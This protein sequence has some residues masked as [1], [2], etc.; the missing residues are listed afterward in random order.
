[1]T[2]SGKR[3]VHLGVAALSL[4]AILASVL[5]AHNVGAAQITDRSLTL[6]P[7]SGGDAGSKPGG[8]VNHFFQFTV[9]TTGTA[10][11]SIKFQYCTTASGTCTMPSNMSSTT[12]TLGSEGSND[13]GFTLN[14]TTNGAPFLYKASATTPTA[15]SLSYTLDGVKNPDGA[16]CS[17]V[18]C[19]FF[20]RIT[21]YQGTDGTTTPIDSGTVAAST[22]TQIILTGTMPESLIFCTGGSIS[23]NGS[24][25]PDCTTATSGS[26]N[27]N[28]L[29]S[30]TQTAYATS[31]MAASTNALSG[32]AITVNGST[33]TSG[34][35]T[36]PA[37]GT[38]PATDSGT[39][40]SSKFGMNLVHDTA[41][42]SLTGAE[43]LNP[44]SANVNP[45]P[46]GVFL[47]GKP[48]A[49]FDTD[50]SYTFDDTSPNVIAKSDNGTGTGAP[51]DAQIFT[52]TYMVNVAGHQVAGTYTTTLTYI[53]TPTF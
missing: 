39:V 21:T 44:L 8:T 32:Y 2:L 22:S 37:I 23:A 13:T 46:D 7:G 1:M 38:T 45:T 34:S 28:R 53:C 20:V 30:P 24:G 3:L 26:I 19:T 35:N 27:F 15:G 4:G 36:I 25:I 40:G 51:T 49:N 31:Q 33:L 41:T 5:P 17:T 11:G 10:I 50:G 14:N 16:D 29:F 42:D 47:M 9:P 52:S 12:A 6:Q 43:V 18:N 48:T